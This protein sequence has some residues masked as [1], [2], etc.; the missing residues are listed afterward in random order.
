MNYA[1]KNEIKL[2]QHH[3]IFRKKINEWEGV[4]LML[5]GTIGAG[6]LGIPYVVASVGLV[7]G[8]I[9]IAI[10][11]I[12]MTLLNM[13]VGEIVVR[14][15]EKKQIIGLAEKY[16]GKF[17]KF[18]MSVIVYIILFG[19]MLAYIIGVGEAIHQMFGG[20]SVLWSVAFFIAGGIII[21]LGLRTI[22]SI[23][24]FLLFSL[25]IIILLISVGSAKFLDINN[26]IYFNYVSLFLPYG[27]ILFAFHST[28]AVAEVHSLLEDKPVKFKKVILYSGLISTLVYIV[29]AFI[30]VGV[31]G[32]NTTE[33]ATV[34]LGNLIGP[35]MNWL[36]NLFAVFAMGTSFLMVGVSLRDSFTWDFG[37]RKLLSTSLACG[38]PIIIFATGMREF[39]STLE[40]VGGIFISAELIFLLFIFWRARKKGDMPAKSFALHHAFPLVVILL[41]LFTIGAVHNIV[42]LF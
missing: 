13:L 32:K 25:L 2:S 15:K 10:L 33:L 9:Y 19:A 38:I 29:F 17:G 24:F 11:G 30:I 31:T 39:I 21:Y 22:K 8:I 26:M 20:E 1:Q 14:T 3:G 6:I 42:K 16:A 7:A 23:E 5:S 37:F 40:L 35:V 34:G 28:S 4:I 18:L 27:V 41:I 12:F 36:G